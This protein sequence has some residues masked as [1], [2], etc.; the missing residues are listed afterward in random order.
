MK[1]VCFR[2]GQHGHYAKDCPKVDTSNSSKRQRSVHSFG[3]LCQIC[4]S[5]HS[6]FLTVGSDTADD[7]LINYHV[8]PGFGI[9]DS[10]A[11]GHAISAHELDQLRAEEPEAFT[12]IDEGRRKVMCFGGG[13]QTFSRCLYSK[14]FYRSHVSQAH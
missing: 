7:E 4:D 6:P 13:T 9:F 11:T 12:E 2:C 3:D 5:E 10:G 1:P 14:P 8:E